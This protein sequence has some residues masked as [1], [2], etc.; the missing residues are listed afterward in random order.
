MRPGGLRALAGALAAGAL[1]GGCA[2][3]TAYVRPAANPPTAFRENA[4]WKPAHPGDRIVRGAWWSVFHDPALDALEARIAVSNQTLK[5]A[6]AQFEQAR[7]AIGYNRAGLAPQVGSDPGITRASQSQNRATP[8]I[9]GSYADFLLPA[10]VS[11]EADVWGRVRGLVANS[12]A[13]AEASAADVELVSLSL[14]AELAVDYFAL[15]GVDADKELLDEAVAN[16]QK[17]VDLT[18][19]RYRG[20]LASQADLAQAET[21]LETT[22]AQ[23]I[24]VGVERASLEHAIAVLV[25]QSASTFTLPPAAATTEPPRI[26]AGLPADL[27]ER[28]PDIAGAERRVAAASAEIGVA[29]A[30]YY[31]VLSLTGAAGFESASLGSWIAGLSNFW[32]AG[33]AALINVFDA[34]RRRAVNREAQA[35]YAQAVAAYQQSVLVA[36]Q[37][38]EDNLA[39]LRLLDEEAR[40]QAQA[41]SAAERSLTLATNRYRGGV[42]SYL[43]VITAQNAALFNERTAVTLRTRRLA[44]SVLLVKALGG[45]WDASALPQTIAAGGTRR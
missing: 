39:A 40:V 23:A 30:A 19:N 25:G 24:D 31:P 4:D 41:V 45:G 20:G 14:H 29:R 27:L 11:Y 2:P 37:E 34:G 10:S 42:T 16:Y 1:A 33:P 28:R 32:A 21:Q 15:R 38:V 36:F 6:Q 17:A 13:A 35:A 5:A 9:R 18:G 44:A 8:A 22:R 43:E 3:K 7:A 26:P 12:R